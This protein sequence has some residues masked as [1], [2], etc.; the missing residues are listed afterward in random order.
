MQIYHVDNKCT[1]F[2]LLSIVNSWKT[3]RC[4]TIPTSDAKNKYSGSFPSFISEISEGV[5][6]QL[7]IG[8]M[9]A[10]RRVVLDEI[11]S[12][13]IAEFVTVRKTQRQIKLESLNQAVKTFSFDGRVVM[14][15][16]VNVNF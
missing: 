3:G 6:S 11:I 16:N 1:P 10:A 2:T 12:N 14:H 4:E 9:K 8:I 15:I 7:H 13:I 5:S